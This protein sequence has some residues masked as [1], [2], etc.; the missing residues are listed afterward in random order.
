MSILEG[1]YGLVGYLV[2]FLFVLLVVVFVHELGHFVVARLCGVKVK[3]FSIG[4]GPEI[5]AFVDR[6]G[7]RW[8]LAAIPLGGYVKFIDDM[9]AASAQ[10]G[11]PRVPLSPEDE[12]GRFQTKSIARRAAIVAAGPAANFLLAIA[13]FAFFFMSYGQPVYPPLVGSVMPDS[14][15]AEAGFEEGDLIVAI[16]G[17][18]ISDFGEIQ[19]VVGASATD[20]LR[21][22]V[23]RAGETIE[24]L[25]SPKWQTMDDRFGNEIRVGLLGITRTGEMTLKHYGPLEAVGAGAAQTWYILERSL[26][27]LRNVV[28]GVEP[29]DQLGGPIRVAQ[30]SGQVATL[31]FAALVNLAAVMSVSIGM[32]NLF[33]VPMLDGGHLMFYAVEAVRGRPL[34]ERAQGVGFQ[35]GMTLVLALMLFATWNDIMR[36]TGVG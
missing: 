7:T 20:T 28:L 14:A 1:L 17:S 23:E 2:P 12:A 25:A 13:I 24:L 3:A 16:E 10:T 15:A 22:S 8:R 27:Y 4:F 31:G 5:F 29:A 36:W 18:P 35:I 11:A 30:I 6:K 32:I 26:D 33:P 9:N 21:F 19:R 34:S